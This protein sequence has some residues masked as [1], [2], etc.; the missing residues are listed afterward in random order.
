MQT[1]WGGT[2]GMSMMSWMENLNKVG[3]QWAAHSLTTNLHWS[4]GVIIADFDN[5]KDL[6]IL[7]AQNVGPSYIYENTGATNPDTRFVQ[8]KIT[9]DFRGHTPRVEDVDCDGDLDIAGGPWG[10]H[11]Q[12]NSGENVA[13]PPVRDYMYLQNMTVERGGPAIPSSQRQKNERGAIVQARTCP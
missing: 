7:F 9:N 13:N 4:H 1:H 6:D 3:T 8:H 10:D 5:D 12:A 11:N 2:N